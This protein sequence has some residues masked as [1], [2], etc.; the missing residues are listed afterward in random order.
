MADGA[1][2][3]LTSN[4]GRLQ[5][6]LRAQTPPRNNICRRFAGRS[7]QAKNSRQSWTCYPERT[8][9][10]RR[11]YADIAECPLFNRAGDRR[12]YVIGVGADEPDGSNYDHQNDRQ[13]HRVFRDVLT[14]FVAPQT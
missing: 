11:P 3:I 9:T 8:P 14:L 12:E 5:I 13:H 2:R 1:R 10:E 6:D 7:I 4:W